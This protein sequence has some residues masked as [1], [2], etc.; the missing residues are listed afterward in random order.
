MDGQNATDKRADAGGGSADN[1]GCAAGQVP[2]E[3]QVRRR[4]I[5]LAQR[6]VRE[7]GLLPPLSLDELREHGEVIR[8]EAGLPQ[9]YADFAAL[10]VSNA[11]WQ[12][13]VAA[14]PYERRILLLPQCLRDAQNCPAEMDALGL[15]CKQCGRCIIGVLQARAQKLGYVVLV[16]EGTTVVTQLLA[17]GR[18]DAVIGV[19]C[20]SVLER[21]FPH[22]AAQAIP[23]LAL[24]LLRDGCLNTETDLPWLLET[25]E[26]RRT[27]AGGR[28]FDFETVR[29]EVCGW[30]AP[31]AL[32]ELLS[33][34][35]TQA[36]RLA[37]EWLGRAGKRWRPFLTVCAYQA[38]SGGRA[39]TVRAVA[40]A[41]ECFHKASLVHDDIEDDDDRRY[42]QGTLH[43][44]YGVPVALNVGDLLLGEGYR[45]IAESGFAP[46]R[47]HALLR[48]A[49]A[50]HLALCHGQGEE[51]AWTRAPGMLET[52]QALD[53]FR[54]KTAPA[55]EVALGMGA[56]C[57]DA[58][59][60]ELAALR[61]FSDALGVCYQIR[62]DLED[63][64][65][66]R[67]LPLTPS[68][69]L[70]VACEQLPSRVGAM[71]AATREGRGYSAEDWA[72]VYAEA[73]AGER[74][75]QLLRHYR[76]EATR[77]LEAV[78]NA[79]LKNLLR[80]TVAWIMGE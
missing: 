1:A 66:G 50:A 42:G 22:M 59:A 21:A 41:V 12:D 55:F 53:I 37:R 57:A 35:D 38:L 14:L 43:H 13:T 9:G 47:L 62:D 15:L 72:A 54:L 28:G 79:A 16:A 44:E 77:S 3:P 4:V 45:L 31:E 6:R 20:L 69:L 18:V 61:A 30:F 60:S 17:Q 73:E 19:S 40:V 26:L 58:P 7:H 2:Q 56:L 23:G 70:A 48:A 75:R 11:L 65:E 27:G 76:H 49:S 39:E 67:L 68:I 34:A 33:P 46:E 52:R 24:P 74:A 63:L 10:M 29:G 25:L 78:G 32:A 5:A 36:G 80:R 64:A 51:L 8:A 71:L